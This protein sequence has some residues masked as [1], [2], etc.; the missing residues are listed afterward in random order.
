M[1]VTTIP[2]H[3]IYSGTFEGEGGVFPY[4]KAQERQT[5]SYVVRRFVLEVKR[6][7]KG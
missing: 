6:D 4:C 1:G 7:R 5:D 2:L 3:S